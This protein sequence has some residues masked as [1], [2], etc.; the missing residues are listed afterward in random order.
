MREG[1]P[2]SETC[3]S[4]G[5]RPSP[6]LFAACHVL[7]RL[8]APRHPPNALTSTL[9]R[10]TRRSQ[11]QAPLHNKSRM[12]MLFSRWNNAPPLST[13]ARS[14]SHSP[15]KP[16]SP[17]HGNA[18]SQILPLHPVKDQKTLPRALKLEAKRC[19]SRSSTER[20]VASFMSGGVSG[21][22][23]NRESRIV[24][25]RTPALLARATGALFCTRRSRRNSRCACRARHER[26]CA[27]FGRWWR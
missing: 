10:L 22:P 3:G 23:G 18:A 5:A 14:S 17:H 13:E 11:G 19:F 27:S 16:A 6:Q 24:Q 12:K 20:R 1:L 9:D 7:H 4:T 25:E 15:G 8:L 26:R 2:H 21:C